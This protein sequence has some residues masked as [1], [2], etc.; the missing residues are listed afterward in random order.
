MIGKQDGGVN[1]PVRFVIYN[2]IEIYKNQKIWKVVSE[3]IHNVSPNCPQKEGVRL[4]LKTDNL[5][6][7]IHNGKFRP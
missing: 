7:I 5:K 3:V 1:L 2:I 4:K 6:Y